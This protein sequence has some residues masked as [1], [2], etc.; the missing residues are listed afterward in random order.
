MAGWAVS[1]PEEIPS[2]SCIV[3]ALTS[4]AVLLSKRISSCVPIWSSEN[5]RSGCPSSL[6]IEFR[7]TP[8]VLKN[9]Q[10]FSRI[11][12]LA[13]LY[14]E[15]TK[16]R[17]TALHNWHRS[18]LPF[19]SNPS[20]S[21][22]RKPA[23]YIPPPYP[24]FV[25]HTIPMVSIFTNRGCRDTLTSPYSHSLPGRN[26]IWGRTLCKGH[27]PFYLCDSIYRF[28]P[29]FRYPIWLPSSPEPWETW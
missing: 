1:S 3:F 13:M 26:D 29:K 7:I 21:D 17:L 18:G 15:R 24:V 8:F 16:H 23:G 25:G 11:S 22:V 20:A 2:C 10:L 4:R 27:A 12:W 5:W 9:S 14:P 28:A 6:G 19:P